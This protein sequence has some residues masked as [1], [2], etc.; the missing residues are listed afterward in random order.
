MTDLALLSTHRVFKHLPASER[1]AF[2]AGMRIDLHPTGG[3]IAQGGALDDTVF[4]LMSGHV[5]LLDDDGHSLLEL[6]AGELF[7]A[8]FGHGLAVHAAVAVT[9]SRV[10]AIAATALSGLTERTPAL[11]HFL[12]PALVQTS[13]A[14][15]PGDT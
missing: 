3:D 11:R 12:P 6:D 1:Q 10:A 14:R 15:P 5:A 13:M 9:P 7:G 8:G 2:I 4:W